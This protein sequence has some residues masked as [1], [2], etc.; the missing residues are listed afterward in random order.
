MRLVRKGSFYSVSV[1]P[2]DLVNGHCPSVGVLFDSVAET[3]AADAVGV[4]LTG[5]GADGAD[6]MVRLRETGA[7][8]L[9]QDEESCVVFGMP[10]EAFFRGGAERLVSLSNMAQEILN[11]LPKRAG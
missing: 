9:A 10:R 2:G 8:T 11:L 5:M 4:M 7:R 3:A 6:A 1:K